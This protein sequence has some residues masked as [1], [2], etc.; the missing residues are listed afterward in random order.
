MIAR[1]FGM[2]RDIVVIA[3]LGLKNACLR[4]GGRPV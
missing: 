1:W 2:L 3:A 4:L